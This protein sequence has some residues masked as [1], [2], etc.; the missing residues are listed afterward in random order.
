MYKSYWPVFENQYSH[1]FLVEEPPLA[2]MYS[3]SLLIL[4]AV[5][6]CCYAQ[7]AAEDVVTGIDSITQNLA[8]LAV[9]VKAVS[10]LEEIQVRLSYNGICYS[11]LANVD[12]QDYDHQVS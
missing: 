12:I 9:L 2:T 3:K 1:K 10:N 6:G 7:Q 8:D 4:A 11:V 5:S